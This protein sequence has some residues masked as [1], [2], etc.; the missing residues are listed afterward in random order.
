MTTFKGKHHSIDRRLTW[1]EKDALETTQVNNRDHRTMSTT[2]IHAGRVENLVTG[3]ER[4]GRT[5][6]HAQTISNLEATM[7]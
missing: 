6:K 1:A 5:Q 7:T 3:P 2:G 4:A